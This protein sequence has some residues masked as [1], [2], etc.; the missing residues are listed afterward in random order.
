MERRAKKLPKEYRDKLAPLDRKYHGTQPGQTGPLVRRLDGLEGLVVGPW[1]E[2]SKDLHSLVRV[3]AESKVA[4]VS[5]ARGWEGSDKE[6]GMYTCL[7]P[8]P[9]HKVSV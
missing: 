5:K 6:L 4:M 8:S 9:R 2:A 7:L 3:L 1:G